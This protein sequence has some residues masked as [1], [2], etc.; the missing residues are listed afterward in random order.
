M[1]WDFNTKKAE[2]TKF[3][4]GVT[5]IRVLDDSPFMRWTH[6]IPK[7]SRSINCP[8]KGCP[9]CTI[10]K[11]QKANKEPYAY[12][13]SRRFTMN[14]YNLETERVELMEQGI[15]FFE[16][17]RDLKAD[18]EKDGK[19]L[20][21]V[22]IK[23]RRRGT[24]KDDTS[25]RLDIDGDAEEEVEK[26][27]EDLIKLDEFLA[28]NDPADIQRVVNGEEW[29]DIFGSKDEAED[30]ATPTQETVEVQ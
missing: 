4:V 24:G 28:P 14:I 2:F 21:D 20:K 1:S 16:D 18:A 5:R 19:S 10:R 7:F 8:G 15:G 22:I 12:A 3:P 17:L 9:I 26:F 6:W 30:E 23:V 13:M 29:N 27:Q 11:Q 25:Y